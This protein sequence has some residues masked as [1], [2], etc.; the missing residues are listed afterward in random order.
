LSG[1][2]DAGQPKERT[3]F[4][5]SANEAAK[6][7]TDFVTKGDLLLLKGSRGVKLEKILDA[8]R[9]RHAVKVGTPANPPE[10]ARTGR[11]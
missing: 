10:P 8:L 5:E 9:E 11:D 7:L 6:F 4:F 3:R 1:A 2:I